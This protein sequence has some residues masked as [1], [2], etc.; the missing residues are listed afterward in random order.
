MDGAVNPASIAISISIGA[1]LL[2][3]VSSLGVARRSGRGAAGVRDRAVS[4]L[5]G[6]ALLV[7][8]LDAIAADAVAV[9]GMAFFG[10]VRGALVLT[11]A[12]ALLG[13]VFGLARGLRRGRAS[14]TR[15]AR[16][17]RKAGS[18]AGA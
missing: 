4:I 17:R 10:L 6:I 13:M 11:A 9:W 7:I 1:S 15:S 12:F 2:A 5:F 16:G 18:A 8:V 3:G 14:K